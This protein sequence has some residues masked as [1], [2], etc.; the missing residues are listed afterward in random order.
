M[1]AALVVGAVA[2]ESSEFGELQK[3]AKETYAKVLPCLKQ[4][5][6]SPGGFNFDNMRFPDDAEQHYK[7]TYMLT[8]YTRVLNNYVFL[9]VVDA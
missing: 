2:A 8:L 5:P 1:I 4:R 6:E 3:R 7:G 9:Y